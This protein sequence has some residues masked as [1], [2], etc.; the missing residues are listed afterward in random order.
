VHMRFEVS[1]VVVVV[2]ANAT[3]SWNLVPNSISQLI[4]H[5]NVTYIQS[6]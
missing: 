2:V 5:Y 3:E 6:I 1:P 4:S